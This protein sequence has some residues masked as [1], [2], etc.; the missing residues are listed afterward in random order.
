MYKLAIICSVLL[1][2]V[3]S[4]QADSIWK[5]SAYSFY[6]SKRSP[7]IGDVITILI[8]AESTAISQ[9]G[10]KTSK[11]SGVGLNLYGIQDKYRG[12]GS[13]NNRDLYNANF[14]A[15]DDYSGL[16]QTTRKSK[17][18]TIVSATITDILENGNLVIVGEYSISINDETERIRISGIVR[19]EDIAPD[20]TVPSH[21]IA[22]GQVSVKGEGVVS[23]K[24]TPGVLSKLFNWVF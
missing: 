13:D 23:S 3:S 9:A 17:V 4:L 21:K 5:S 7:K 14:Q 2:T 24:Q 15:K 12:T 1:L 16:G 19:P 11:K 10:T 6:T 22:N 18:E 8:S 20:N